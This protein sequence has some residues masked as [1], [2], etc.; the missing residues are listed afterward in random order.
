MAGYPTRSKTRTL[1]VIVVACTV[2]ALI[3]GFFTR[4]DNAHPA[5]APYEPLTVPT[6]P[7]PPPVQSE[8][9]AARAAVDG[10]HQ[11]ALANIGQADIDATVDRYVDPNSP[12]LADPRQAERDYLHATQGLVSDVTTH[13]LGWQTV[14][15]SS[16]RATIR[17]AT[18]EDASGGAQY[19]NDIV[20]VWNGLTDTWR[21]VLPASIEANPDAIALLSN[22]RGF[23]D[24]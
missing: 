16:E 19:V 18:S 9:G 6:I 3:W 21:L 8:E 17:F 22:P 15:F 24:A 7:C 5:P 2:G 20:V 1:F 11:L 10:L 4:G 13:V 12:T 14:V 23:C